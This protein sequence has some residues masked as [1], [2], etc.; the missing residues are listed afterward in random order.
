MPRK[1]AESWGQLIPKLDVLLGYY[2]HS[3]QITL[4]SL[5][6]LIIT[7][8]VKQ[9]MTDKLHAYVLQHETGGWYCPDD[10]AH[11]AEKFEDSQIMHTQCQADI[12]KKGDT[13]H[14]K[15]EDDQRGH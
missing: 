13:K 2:L 3:Q 6:S 14:H 5:H 11:V 12:P 1:G 10:I 4:E 7:D 9:L 8:R 15:S